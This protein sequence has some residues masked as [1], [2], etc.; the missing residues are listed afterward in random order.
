M[1]TV[2]QIEDLMKIS[3]DKYPIISLYFGMTPALRPQKKYK[4]ITKTLIKKGTSNLSAFNDEQKTLI[5]NDSDKIIHFI[6]YEFDGKPKGLAIFSST[7]LGLWQVYPLPRRVKGR[8][9]ID[10]DPYTRPLVKLLDENERYFIVFVDKKR[11]RL[12]SSYTGILNERNEIFDEVMGQ[13]KQGGWS[14]ARFQRHIKDQ[15]FKHLTNVANVLH[16]VYK[17]E[18]FDHLI[19]GGSNESLFSLR[20]MLHSSLQRIIVGEINGSLDDS[21]TR[22]S[23]S[24]QKTIDS[25]EK[26]QSEKYL[27]ALFDRLGKKQPAVSGLEETV[28]ML[29]QAR[30]HTLIVKED[31]MLPGYKC[32]NCETPYITDVKKC[33][34]CS[35]RIVKTTDIID[36]I[37]EK[38][39]EL[40]GEVKFI[41]TNKKL[42]ASDGIGALLRW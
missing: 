38:V 4:T 5:E 17:Q 1:I 22:L 33:S 28:K 36:E 26:R 6:E 11:A 27:K 15:S 13:H 32:T 12:F 16:K 31:L 21:R 41:K 30:I 39:W 29:Y 34:F 42:D 23:S 2:K 40:N 19:L 14:Q 18:K 20:N 8:F 37:I 10:S 9:I 25:F 35:K 7:G 3:S 24:I